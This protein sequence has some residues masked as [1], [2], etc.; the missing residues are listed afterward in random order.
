[1]RQLIGVRGALGAVAAIAACLA[2]S[3][4]ALAAPQSGDH[5]LLG[6]ESQFMCLSCHEPLEL[7]SSPQAQ[8]EKG[9]LKRLLAQG[10]DTS[11]IRAAMVADYGKLVL[12]A[13]PASGFNLLLY[14]L[15]PALLVAGIG[16]LLYT[17]PKWRARSRAAAATPL[18]AGPPLA[19]GEAKRLDDEL[20]RFT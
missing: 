1:V 20:A 19:P 7:V 12:A 9:T 11:Q 3:P 14:V 10:D 18:A 16:G 2:L 13:P 8:Q 15:P 6:L 4:P 5:A 17:L